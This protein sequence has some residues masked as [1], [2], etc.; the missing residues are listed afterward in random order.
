MTRDDEPTKP[1]PAADL[2]GPASAEAATEPLIAPHVPLADVSTTELSALAEP[3]APRGRLGVGVLAVVGGFAAAAV[4]GTVLLLT[5]TPRGGTAVPDPS[6]SPSPTVTV[7]T[8]DDS[9]GSGGSDAPATPPPPPVEP[10]P[11]PT[12][13]TEPTPEPTAT[14]TP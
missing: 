12:T 8:V 9:D 4:I 10:S 7:D 1:L 13:T 6:T 3:V 11:E 2:S 5:L 14:D